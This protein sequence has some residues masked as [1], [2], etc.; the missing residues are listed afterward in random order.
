MFH[1]T[2]ERSNF[3]HDFAGDLIILLVIVMTFYF[4]MVF[5]F[6]ETVKRTAE[7]Y[8]SRYAKSLARDRQTGRVVC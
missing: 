4:D 2:I 1:E 5:E 6:P 8:T 3:R 7:G